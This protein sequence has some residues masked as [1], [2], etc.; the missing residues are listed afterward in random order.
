[1][2]EAEWTRRV[3]TFNQKLQ[4]MGAP[5]VSPGFL[6]SMLQRIGIEKLRTVDADELRLF[7]GTAR[8]FVGGRSK[9][10]SLIVLIEENAEDVAEAVRAAMAEDLDGCEGGSDG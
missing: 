10:E 1:M 6:Y 3:A 7:A 8:R 2:H 4:D 5:H 9:L